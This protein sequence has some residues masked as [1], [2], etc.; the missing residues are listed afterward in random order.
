MKLLLENWR[1]HVNEDESERLDFV[2]DKSAW[3]LAQNDA[4]L[5]KKYPQEAAELK[6]R[7]LTDRYLA[8]ATAADKKEGKFLHP[9]QYLKEPDKLD[10]Y[11]GLAQDTPTAASTSSGKQA[12]ASN[13]E[14]MYDDLRAYDTKFQK[15]PDIRKKYEAA[16]GAVNSLLRSL[17]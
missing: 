9:S 10:A 16:L 7:G 8:A 14:K 1:K 2:G 3:K 12:V 6:K 17:K 5:P 4:V 13:I 15:N 11:L